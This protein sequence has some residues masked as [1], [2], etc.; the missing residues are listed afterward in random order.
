MSGSVGAA[1]AVEFGK[2]VFDT[3]GFDRVYLQECSVPHWERGEPEVVRVVNSNTMGSVDLNALALG[4][5]GATGP[6]GLTAEVIKVNSL[7][8]LRELDDAAVEG[9]IVFFQRADGP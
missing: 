4:F 8:E 5:S 1:A 2:Q 9:K 6:G 7:E 3:L